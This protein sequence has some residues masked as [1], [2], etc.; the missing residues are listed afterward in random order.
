MSTY[1]AKDTIHLINNQ[2]IPVGYTLSNS[3]Y[4]LVCDSKQEDRVI[5]EGA[6][7]YFRLSDAELNAELDKLAEEK[8]RRIKSLLP[9]TQT[10]VSPTTYPQ[11]TPQ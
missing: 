10:E 4:Q 7:P 2:V 8:A 1:I 11:E 5:I 9:E 3:E 6:L